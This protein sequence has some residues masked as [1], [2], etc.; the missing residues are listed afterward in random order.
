MFICQDCGAL[1]EDIITYQ[2]NNTEYFGTPCSETV[3]GCPYCG[4]YCTE[5]LQCDECGEYIK[6]RYIVTRNGLKICDEC[7]ISARLK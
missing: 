3:S 1:C 4:G 6:D 7:Y 2:D 5:T